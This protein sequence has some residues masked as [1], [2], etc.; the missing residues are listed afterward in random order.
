MF[1]KLKWR[2]VVLIMSMLI[3]VFVGIFGAIYGLTA[4]SM[5]KQSQ[6]TLE[7]I[8]RAPPR[9]VPD[10]RDAFG[11]LIVETDYQGKILLLMS[12]LEVDEQAVAAA[13]EKILSKATAGSEAG[14][15]AAAG[16]VAEANQDF[17]RV[18]IGE[19]SY[20]YLVSEMPA[21]YKMVLLD[22]TPVHASLNDLLM[23]FIW[24]GVGSLLVLFGV[25]VFF[26]SRAV[27][28][29]QAAFEKQQQFLADASHELRTPLTV[30]QTQLALLGT[31]GDPQEARWIEGIKTETTNMAGLVTDMLDLAKLDHVAEPVRV[32]ASLKAL[33]EK[34]LLSYEAIFFERGIE[35]SVSSDEEVMARMDPEGIRRVLVILLD[36]A[37][38]YTPSGGHVEIRLSREKHKAWLRV[39][40]T[41]EGIPEDRLEAIF[42]RFVRL[43]A[44]RT[45]ATGGYGLG[46]AIARGIAEQ[47][48]GRLTASSHPGEWTEMTLVL[49]G[50]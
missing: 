27:K 36:N 26:A 17:G 11:S 20:D 37:L 46:L 15:E 10:S 9:P 1:R 44:S 31:L 7:K 19:T 22:R 48:G 35:L 16:T 8:M 39:R 43:D 34:C 21:G 40:N 33:L 25:S 6:F 38:K 2:F 12:Y 45:K 3:L 28:P 4:N 29:I 41:G 49:P 30:I 32:E 23:V 18:K 42:D 47:H 13:V 24:V 50:V 5:N 14:T